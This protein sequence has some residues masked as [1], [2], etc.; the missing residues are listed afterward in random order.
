MP[1]MPLISRTSRTNE[2]TM[3]LDSLSSSR[4]PTSMANRR[5]SRMVI[6][7]PSSAAANTDIRRVTV[8]ADVAD[9]SAPTPSVPSICFTTSK[10]PV[11]PFPVTARAMI[12]NTAAAVPTD[13]T[14]VMNRRAAPSSSSRSGLAMEPIIV[15]V[16]EV[17]PG[18]QPTKPPARAPPI[19]AL[20][21]RSWL[22]SLH[23]SG[24]CPEE[25]ER[26]RVG[27]PN[28]P[29][30]SGKSMLPSTPSQTPV[31]G[32]LPFKATKPISPEDNNST[33][34]LNLFP[35][36]FRRIFQTPVTCALPASVPARAST[37]HSPWAE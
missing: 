36:R 1:G 3:I 13:D 27:R 9:E 12:P 17:T 10:A 4:S 29:V 8:S 28:R 5:P 20:V 26:S 23:C 11:R 32:S 16:V 2:T 21:S 18:T 34:A 31:K 37:V 6:R 7:Y 19:A 30:R 35:D 24:I 22:T 15:P 14:M 33:I 25:P